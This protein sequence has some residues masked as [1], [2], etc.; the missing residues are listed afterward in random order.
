MDVPGG[1][2]PEFPYREVW[3]FWLLLQKNRKPR[4]VLIKILLGVLQWFLLP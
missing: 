2:T 1:T 3:F 4:V